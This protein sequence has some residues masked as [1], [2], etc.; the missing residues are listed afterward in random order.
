MATNKH[1][2]N[3]LAATAKS[4]PVA[5]GLYVMLNADRKELIK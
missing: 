5:P 2:N 1:I 3:V 4:F